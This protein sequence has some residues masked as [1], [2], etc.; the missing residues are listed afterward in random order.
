MDLTLTEVA[1]RETREMEYIGVFPS[2]T[3]GLTA[4]IRWLNDHDIDALQVNLIASVKDDGSF[5]TR[6][7]FT[8]RE[9]RTKADSKPEI[10]RLKG[11]EDERQNRTGQD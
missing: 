5:E 10:I 8:T 7:I 1:V 4:A 6:A 3:M 2:P 9:T 11:N